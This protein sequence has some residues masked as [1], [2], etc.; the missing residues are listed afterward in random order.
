MPTFVSQ[1]TGPAG[2]EAA[3]AATLPAQPLGRLRAQ[4]EGAECIST[5]AKLAVQTS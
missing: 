1:P 4:Q 2:E 5:A 3:V